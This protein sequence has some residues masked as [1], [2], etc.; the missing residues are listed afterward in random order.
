MHIFALALS[1]LGNPNH[2][3]FARCR[4]LQL[5]WLTRQHCGVLVAP[6]CVALLGLL[7]A[8]L[9]I[10]ALCSVLYHLHLLPDVCLLP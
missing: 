2:G 3:F 10:S 1:P 8:S 9:Q 4:D 6:H 5:A 7:S